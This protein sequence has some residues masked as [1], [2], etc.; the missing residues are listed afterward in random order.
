MLIFN[1]ITVKSSPSQLLLSKTLLTEYQ[2]LTSPQY[3]DLHSGSLD[4]IQSKIMV[5]EGKTKIPDLIINLIIVTTD[6][7]SRYSFEIF[8]V[9]CHLIRV[10]DS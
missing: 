6:S 2:I 9:I 1:Q 7:A 4:I 8:F 5:P 10:C 3:P